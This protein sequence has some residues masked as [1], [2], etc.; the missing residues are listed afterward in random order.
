MSHTFSPLFIEIMEDLSRPE[1]VEK[2]YNGVF[3]NHHQQA[4]NVQQ[5]TKNRTLGQG[6]YS[7][8]KSHRTD[9]HLVQKNNHRQMARNTDGFNVFVEWLIKQDKLD[10]IHF[11]RIY[12]I[13]RITDREDNVVHSYE[14]EKLI[15]AAD[16]TKE[17]ILA[18]HEH[19][20][21]EDTL[22]LDGLLERGF[23]DDVFKAQYFNHLC[24]ALNRAVK[25]KIF[26]YFL[27]DSMKTAIATLIEASHDESLPQLYIDF[28]EGNLMWRRGPTGLT[29]VFSDPY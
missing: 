4:F 13:K 22:A 27:A 6:F 21:H 1:T 23:N 11:P 28:H 19:N 20:I 8:V 3:R 26:S 17:E 15:K 14:M 9:P 25:Q 2:R 12:N 7:N 29:L 24:H 16:V 10:N 18:F 5:S